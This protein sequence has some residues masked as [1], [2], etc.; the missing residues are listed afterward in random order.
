MN[1]RRSC[2][3]DCIQALFC[4]SLELILV[5]CISVTWDLKSS[6]DFSGAVFLGMHCSRL[7][8][9]PGFKLVFDVR[10]YLKICSLLAKCSV[11]R[12]QINIFLFHYYCQ[13]IVKKNPKARKQADL[14]FQRL[15]LMSMSVLLF[16]FCPLVMI[17]YILILFHLSYPLLFLYAE[18]IPD[19]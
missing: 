8:N 7:H 19:S 13:F 4:G 5:P 16:T 9:L 2:S 18:I 3:L 15:F 11:L 12:I 17:K 10:E 1:Y 6:E 14:V